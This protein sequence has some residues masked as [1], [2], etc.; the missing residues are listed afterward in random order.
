MKQFERL[1]ESAEVPVSLL[2][3]IAGIYREQRDF[4]AAR[5]LYE[6]ALTLEPGDLQTE[7][8]LVMTL[9]DMGKYDEALARL[10]DNGTPGRADDK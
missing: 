4:A 2:K 5:A 1:P 10:G 8:R 7:R 6:R 3:T 9:F